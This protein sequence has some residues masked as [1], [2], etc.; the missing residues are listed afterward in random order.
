MLPTSFSL[1]WVAGA[2]GL[3]RSRRNGMRLNGGFPEAGA[4]RHP[5]M[6]EHVTKVGWTTL[7]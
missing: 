3:C 1:G 6:L 2:H 7:D 4:P 5:V